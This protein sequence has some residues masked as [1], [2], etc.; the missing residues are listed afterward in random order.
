MSA[1]GWAA[2]AAALYLTGLL[3][4]FGYRSIRHRRITGDIGFRGF[5]DPDPLVRAS[6][7]LFVGAIVIGL[8][9]LVLGA[10]AVVPTVTIGGGAS[11]LAVPGVV[12]ALL[13]FAIVWAAQTAMGA[14]WRIG[15]DEGETTALVTDG[16]FGRVRNP[17][18]TAMMTAQAGT[19]LMAPSWLSLLGLLV[20]IL[21]CEMQVRLVEEPY[22]RA[23]HGDRYRAY[24]A[25]AGR[26]LPGIGVDRSARTRGTRRHQPR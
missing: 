23:T 11:V 12:V 1:E 13:S 10:T 3:V 20:L 8:T 5:S 15:V 14:S 9:S 7:A 24:T 4:L 19:V 25:R 2:W 26:F 22:L 16:I 21:G 6:G 18:F 17:I